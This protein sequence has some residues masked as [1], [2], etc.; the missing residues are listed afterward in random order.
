[1]KFQG[2]FSKKNIFLEGLLQ[3]L[4][5][6][7]KVKLLLQGRQLMRLYVCFSV[8]L[9]PSEKGGLS[10]KE[11]NFVSKANSYLLA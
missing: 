2:F 1:M 7:L 8:H 10:L 9:P 3:I 6:A 4:L 11:K 5:G